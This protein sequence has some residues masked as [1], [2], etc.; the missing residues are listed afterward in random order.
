MAYDVDVSVIIPVF[1]QESCLLR[2]LESVLMQ[3]GISLE[4]ICVDDGS[5]DGSA[6]ILDE[7]QRADSRIVVISQSNQGAGFARNVGIDAAK[8]EYVVFCD[9]DDLIPDKSAYSKLYHAAKDHD[10][11]ISAG[12]FSIVSNGQRIDSFESDALLGGYT[13]LRDGMIQYKDYQFDYGFM[14]FMFNRDFLNNEGLRFTNYSR[15]EDPVF[16]VRAL[17]QAS[18]FY[19]ITDI[20]YEYYLGHQSFAW[21]KARI[22]D[23][24]KG[25]A[26]NLDYSS[27]ESL[28][29]LH[30]LTLKRIEEEYGG[31]YSLASLDAETVNALIEL[32]SKVDWGLIGEMEK[33]DESDG[34]PKVILPLRNIV[35]DYAWRCEIS[36]S[37]AFKFARYASAVPRILARKLKRKS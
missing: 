24:V 18:C 25:L 23:L 37:R 22:L 28:D 33:P 4:I 8:G 10:A 32:N 31:I 5:T 30:R 17:H 29:E 13:F 11:L 12:S 3:T 2:C 19:A 20:V 34:T 14:R 7:M 1:N 16:L 35:N 26:D 27:R 9:G 15:F 36:N 6:M 21:D